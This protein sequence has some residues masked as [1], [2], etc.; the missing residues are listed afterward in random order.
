[1]HKGNKIKYENIEEQ[2]YQ[3][4]AYDKIKEAR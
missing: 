3:N 4:I 2:K 1:M